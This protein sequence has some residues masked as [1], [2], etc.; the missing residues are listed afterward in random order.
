MTLKKPFQPYNLRMLDIGEFKDVIEFY[1]EITAKEIRPYRLEIDSNKDLFMSKLNKL[2]EL[3]AIDKDVKDFPL[4]IKLIAVMI[5]ARGDASMAQ[6]A[7]KT[8]LL[9]DDVGVMRSEKLAQFFESERYYFNGK[10]GRFKGK[11]VETLGLRMCGWAI[12]E[13]HPEEDAD[14]GIENTLLSYDLATLIGVSEEAILE[15]ERYAKN[16][17]AFGK[18]IYEFEE[19]RGF[20]DRGKSLVEGVR[21]AL[22]NLD[23]PNILVYSVLDTAYYCTDKALQIFGGY[24]FII[25]YPAQ[26]FLRDARMLRSLLIRKIQ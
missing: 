16:R 26:K 10:F 21:W 2:R 3:G 14:E 7:I 18:P 13:F 4:Y 22:L 12:G 25:D 1:E 6:H 15:A 5:L 24:G 9:G 19:I 8:L 17:K 23:D 20:I 11:Y